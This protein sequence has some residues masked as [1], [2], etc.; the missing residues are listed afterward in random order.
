M[1][2]NLQ[3]KK[4]YSDSMHMSKDALYDQ[5]TSEYGEK[6]TQEAAQYAIDNVDAN[7]NENALNKAKI[8]QKD[9]AM[10]PS[11]I[12]DQLVSE[13]GEKFTEEEAQYAIDNLE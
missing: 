2:K 12:Y 8:Y 11:A 10:S 5:L 4:V 3:K 6:F 1:E 7:W 13:Y 9:M